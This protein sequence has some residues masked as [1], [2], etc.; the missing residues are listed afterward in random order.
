[1]ILKRF[2][3][4]LNESKDKNI[5]DLKFNSEYATAIFHVLDLDDLREEE[6]MP[7][8]LKVSL[9]FT[10]VLD[11]LF[12]DEWK[13]KE[14]K[15]ISKC[16]YLELI[17]TKPNAPKGTGTELLKDAFSKMELNNSIICLYASPI[18]PNKKNTYSKEQM[19]EFLPKLMGVYEK[20][21]FVSAKK[22]KQ[23]MYLYK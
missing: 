6:I 5:K 9:D 18:A 2:K 17:K 7:S 10:T 23:V 15:N 14:K 4:F 16:V 20:L 11:V 21:G 13:T 8:D 3:T 19:A 12:D 1:M 22:N